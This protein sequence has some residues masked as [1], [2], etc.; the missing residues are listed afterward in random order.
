MIDLNFEFKGKCEN[1]AHVNDSG[2]IKI[3]ALNQGKL[4]YATT[5]KLFI[6]IL[7]WQFRGIHLRI[8]STITNP[9]KCIPASTNDMQYKH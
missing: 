4:E 5:N 8:K 9:G 1:I 7:K 2:R 6:L 3:T